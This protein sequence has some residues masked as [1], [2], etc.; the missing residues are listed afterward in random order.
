MLKMLTF[1]PQKRLTAQ[2]ALQHPYFDGFTYNPAQLVQP[3]S[4]GGQQ[5]VLPGLPGGAGPGGLNTSNRNFF[6]NPNNDINKPSSNSKRIESRKGILSRKDSVNKNNFYLQKGKV[7]DYLPNKPTVVGSRGSEGIA[8]SYFNKN[9]IGSGGSGSGQS[10]G[11][12]LPVLGNPYQSS[13]AKNSALGGNRVKSLPPGA[14]GAPGG[15]PGGYMP[16]YKYGGVGGGA[17][18]GYGEQSQG[19]QGSVGSSHGHNNNGGEHRLPTIQSRQGRAPDSRGQPLS[20]ITSIPKYNSGL[21]GAGSSIIGGAGSAS[22]GPSSQSVPPNGGG[23]YKYGGGAGAS[24]GIGGAIGTL[25]QAPSYN[26]GSIPKYSTSGIAGGIG[27]L[28]LGGGANSSG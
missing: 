18:A 9:P 15:G 19:A 23:G 5:S 6:Q 2:Q 20:G 1:D 7:P 14:T 17:D 22:L 28:G 26:F 27:S 11:A 4:S 16:S 10:A 13:V 8:N 12:M 25:G 3:S 24:S 21:G